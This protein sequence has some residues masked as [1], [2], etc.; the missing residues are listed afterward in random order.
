MAASIVLAV[1]VGFGLLAWEWRHP[2]AFHDADG[3]ISMSVHS[4]PVGKVIFVG[5]TYGDESAGEV[6]L[7]RAK[8]DVTVN[9]AEANI[10][11]YV[12]TPRQPGNGNIGSNG[13]RSHP[14]SMRDSRTGRWS[15]RFPPSRRRSSP[16]GSHP[17]HSW[18][19]PG[20][21]FD[22]HLPVGVEERKSAGGRRCPNPRGPRTVVAIGAS[23]PREPQRTHLPRM[24]NSTVPR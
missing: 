17:N 7:V 22:S 10:E 8:P 19:R 6:T 9:S 16:D 13:S 3:S 1:V 11:Y 18:C 23:E 12:C 15:D 21:E 2:D 4:W 5:V 14:A 24:V 20:F